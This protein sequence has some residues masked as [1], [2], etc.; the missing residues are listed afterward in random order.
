MGNIEIHGWK[1]RKKKKHYI[2]QLKHL[3]MATLKERKFRVWTYSQ[4]RSREPREVVTCP[5][6]CLLHLINDGL[7][8]KNFPV[9]LL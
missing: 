4:E 2:F 7:G 5:Q 1:Y 3:G 8:W 9:P 6:T